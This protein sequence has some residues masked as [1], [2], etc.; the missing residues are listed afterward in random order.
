MREPLA[1]MRS[2][3]ERK[4][5]S[6]LFTNSERPIPLVWICIKRSWALASAWSR[7]ENASLKFSKVSDERTVCAASDCT[8]LSIF[9]NRWFSSA[10]IVAC[11]SSTRFRSVISVSVTME[12]T[13]TFLSSKSGPALSRN[14]RFDRRS[15]RNFTSTP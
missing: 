3:R 9:L 8:R 5:E 6:I 7:P 15:L 2:S 12:P 14:T 10:A 13:D 11:C 1:L 4:G